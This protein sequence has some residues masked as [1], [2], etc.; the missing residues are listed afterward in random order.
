[1]LKRNLKQ[2]K[3][4]APRVSSSSTSQKPLGEKLPG[5]PK[6]ANKI[7]YISRFHKPLSS[8][9]KTTATSSVI[10]ESSALRLPVKKKKVNAEPKKRIAKS[11]PPPSSS[12]SSLSS[13]ASETSVQKIQPFTKK[14]RGKS[15]SHKI[16]HKSCSKAKARCLKCKFRR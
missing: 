4:L 16:F 3:L 12:L 5:V 15:S 8:K 2:K 1:P 14:H 11:A 10:G 9:F 13:N 7:K 6:K